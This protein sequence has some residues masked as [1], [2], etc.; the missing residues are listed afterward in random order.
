MDM[1][2]IMLVADGNGPI[3]ALQRRKWAEEY[4]LDMRFII[5]TEINGIIDR[6]TYKFFQ[7]LLIEQFIEEGGINGQ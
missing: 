7:G 4:A 3:V 1:P 2:S 5:L 6:A